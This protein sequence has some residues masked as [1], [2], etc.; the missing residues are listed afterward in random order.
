MERHWE[1]KLNHLC[2]MPCALPNVCW[3]PVAVTKPDMCWPEGFDPDA[4]P[5]PVC[6][7]EISLAFYAVLI[8]VLAFGAGALVSM[9]AHFCGKG[10]SRFVRYLHR[11]FRVPRPNNTSAAPAG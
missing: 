6:L 11:R 1:K 8:A 4:V 7:S 10:I 9:L 3:T 2:D 5:A